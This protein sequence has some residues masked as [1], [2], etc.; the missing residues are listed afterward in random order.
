V[1]TFRQA[2]QIEALVRKHV[3][4]MF[5]RVRNGK[6]ETASVVINEPG[7]R[8]NVSYNAKQRYSTGS[9]P[10]YRAAYSLT[11]NPVYPALKRSSINFK[12]S[13]RPGPLGIAA[14]ERQVSKET[15]EYPYRQRPSRRSQSLD[16]VAWIPHV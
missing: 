1:S 2:S 3:G 14:T 16:C 4:P 12:K 5:E 11:R 15:A 13:G 9:Y 6:L 8:A 7:V 10:S